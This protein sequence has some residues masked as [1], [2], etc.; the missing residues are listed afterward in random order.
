MLRKQA[1]RSFTVEIKHSTTSGRSFIPTKPPQDLGRGRHVAGSTSPLAA[2][3]EQKVMPASVTGEAVEPR[4]IL[5]SLIVWEPSPA[6]P[7]FDVQPETPLP[8]VR[9]AASLQEAA[10]APRRRGRPPKLKLEPELAAEVAIPIPSG[11]M[12]PLPKSPVPS[13]AAPVTLVRHPRGARIEGV[14]LPRAERWKRRLP[15]ACW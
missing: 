6:E 7:E 2:I 3:F 13:Q 15:R 11:P 12:L 1:R 14:G 9:R 10:D 5:P 8:P 4:R